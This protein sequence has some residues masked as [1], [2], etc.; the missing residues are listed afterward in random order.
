MNKYTII[1][2]VL[3]IGLVTGIYGITSIQQADAQTK[4]LCKG[5]VY[6]GKNF[7]I[8]D[9]PFDADQKASNIRYMALDSCAQQGWK[10]GSIGFTLY[11]QK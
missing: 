9:F 11:V 8:F 7:K 10:I 6:D 3:T 4:N 5:T 1:G 2:L